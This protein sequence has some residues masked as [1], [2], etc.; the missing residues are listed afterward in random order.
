MLIKIVFPY[1]I[2]LVD[3]SNEYFDNYLFIITDCSLLAVAIF[4]SKRINSL[5]K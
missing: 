1:S 2:Y 3:K 4:R 5:K